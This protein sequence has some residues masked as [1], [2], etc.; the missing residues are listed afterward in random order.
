[1]VA[2]V[3]TPKPIVNLLYGEIAKLLKSPDI[4]SRYTADGAFAVGNPPDDFS[5]R[6]R[7]ETARWAGIFKAAGMKQ[8][9]F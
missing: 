1:M 4:V 6:I 2:P 5:E 8:E 9:A 7:N 3:A